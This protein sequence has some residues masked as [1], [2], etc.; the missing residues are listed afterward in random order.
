MFDE[1]TPEELTELMDLSA[2]EHEA[3]EDL[4]DRECGP[5]S[6]LCC[7]GGCY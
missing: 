5:G 6:C 1:K 3:N 7:Y 2:T 4:G